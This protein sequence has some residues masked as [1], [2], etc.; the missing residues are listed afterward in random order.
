MCAGMPGIFHR[1]LAG[2]E[3]DLLI[4]DEKSSFEGLAGKLNMPVFT[5]VQKWE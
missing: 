1:S 3:I 2:M 4:L 5:V